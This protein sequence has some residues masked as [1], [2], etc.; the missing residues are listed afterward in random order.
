MPKEKS[1][2]AP[3]RVVYGRAIMYSDGYGERTAVS[4]DSAYRLGSPHERFVKVEG[5]GGH[6]QVYMEDVPFLIE[7]L[8]AIRELDEEVHA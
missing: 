7:H 3:S 8:Q 5:V 2:P 1:K 4:Y 6:I